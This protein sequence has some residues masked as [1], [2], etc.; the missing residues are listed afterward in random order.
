VSEVSAE[1][2]EPILAQVRQFVRTKVVPREAEILA[3]DAI[4]VDLRKQ[5]AEMGLFG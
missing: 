2:F 5:A 3:T 1:D 4:P